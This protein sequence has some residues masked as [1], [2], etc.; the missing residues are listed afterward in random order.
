MKL[1]WENINYDKRNNKK[2]K[3]KKKKKKEKQLFLFV[4]PHFTS[5]RV[6]CVLISSIVTLL[7]VGIIVTYKSISN[8][9]D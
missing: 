1:H 8:T 3:K 4:Q 2:E 7:N 6:F 9:I 5:D